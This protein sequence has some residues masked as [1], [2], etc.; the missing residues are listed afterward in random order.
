MEKPARLE[1]FGTLGP[2]CADP[3]IL[4]ELFEAGMTGVRLNLSHTSLDRCGGWLR[5]LREASSRAGA[6]PELLIDLRGPELRIGE[7]AVPVRLARGERA[8]LG[9]GG[10]RSPG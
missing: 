9:E 4:T 1:Y 10:L 8:V 7:L 2:A 3:D 5:S 6:R